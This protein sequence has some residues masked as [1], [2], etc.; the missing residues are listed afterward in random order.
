[1]RFY[2]SRQTR[3]SPL[4]YTLELSPEETE[5]VKKELLEIINKIKG[6]EN[7]KAI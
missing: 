5:K 4:K 6:E 3:T 2:E 7:E 1:M